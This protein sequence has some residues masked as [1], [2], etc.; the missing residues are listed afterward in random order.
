LKSKHAGGYGEKPVTS[1]LH[2]RE[3]SNVHCLRKDFRQVE[4][5]S[6]EGKANVHLENLKT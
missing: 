6:G 4:I 5:I 2:S 1:T 3:N